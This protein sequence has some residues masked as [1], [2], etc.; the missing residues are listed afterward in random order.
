MLIIALLCIIIP[1]CGSLLYL[2]TRSNLGVWRKLVTL[3]IA[4][5]IAVPVGGVV[6]LVFLVAG[7]VVFWESQISEYVSA[8]WISLPASAAGNLVLVLMAAVADNRAAHKMEEGGVKP[9]ERSDTRSLMLRFGLAS[10]IAIVI[11][12]AA[13]CS[14]AR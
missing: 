1:T 6:C 13:I 9:L 8:V 7:T 2:L 11:V 12:P 10:A 4:L 3:I 14:F 5:A